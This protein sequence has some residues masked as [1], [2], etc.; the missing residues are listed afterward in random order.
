MQAEIASWLYSFIC[1]CIALMFTALTILVLYR[2]VLL[3][4]RDYMLFK[5]DR[6]KYLNHRKFWKNK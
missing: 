2:I 6:L 1:G 5:T 3:A 4:I